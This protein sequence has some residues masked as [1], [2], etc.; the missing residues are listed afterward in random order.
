MSF[1]APTKL[2]SGLGGT[3]LFFGA[4]GYGLY[5]SMYNVE[6]GYRAVEFNRLVGVKSEVKRDGTHFVIP[7]LEWPTI[8]D[9]KTQLY[10]SS[11]RTGTRDLQSVDLQLRVLFKPIPEELPSIHK[12][13]GED[14]VGKILPSIVHETLRSVIAQYKADQL[15]SQREEVSQKIRRGLEERALDFHMLIDDVAIT[16]LRFGKEFSQAIENKQIAQQ[17]SARAKFVVMKALEDKKSNIIRAQGEAKS[18]EMIGSAIKQNPGF[19]ELRK[20][21]AAR[22]IASTISNSNNKIFLNSESLLLNLLNGHRSV[23]AIKEEVSN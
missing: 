10:N 21:E 16:E 22:E 19:V 11:A 17:E 23:S 9:I 12:R 1:A 20:L 8:Y 5:H 3:A 14:Y 18:A 15:I 2:L 6:G 4:A 13:F 7:W